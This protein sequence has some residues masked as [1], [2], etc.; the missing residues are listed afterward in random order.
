MMHRQR[1]VRRDANFDGIVVKLQVAHGYRYQRRIRR[2]F[3][4]AAIA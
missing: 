2:Q 4:N 1:T 3:D